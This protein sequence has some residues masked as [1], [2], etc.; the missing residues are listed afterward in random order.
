[1]NK[2]TP[3]IGLE[4]HVQLDTKSKLFCSCNNESFDAAP[5]TNICPICSGQP[6][7]L[8][9]IN[10]TAILYTVKAGI[11]MHCDINK[12]SKWDRKSYFYPDLPKG[13]QISQYDKP[14]CIGGYIDILLDNKEEKRIRLNRI[15]LEEDAGKSI[16]DRSIEYTYLDYNRCGTPLIEIVSEPDL[17]SAS[18]AD[19]YGKEIRRIVRYLGISRADM[20]K[21]HMRFDINVNVKIETDNNETKYTP[22]VEVK[23]LNSFKALIKAIE[24]EIN[25]QIED[26]EKTGITKSEKNKT[27]RLWNDNKGITSQMRTKEEAADYR[28]FPDPDLVPIILDD[29]YINNVK[30]DISELPIDKLKKYL[31]LG[32]ENNISNYIVDN[33]NLAD[34]LDSCL[35][36]IGDNKE[37][38]K[39]F[40]NWFGR[41]FF[42]LLNQVSSN[43]KIEDSS[44]IKITEDDF[45]ELITLIVNKKITRNLAKEFLIDMWDNDK[46]LIELKQ[47]IPQESLDIDQIINNVLENNQNMIDQYKNGNMKVFNVL[48]GLV[49]KESKGLINPKDITNK[50]KEILEK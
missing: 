15:H 11:A 33:K 7:T 32:L 4:T 23:N 14:L 44:V 37:M 47:Q 5:N 12:Y 19:K 38:Q 50:L 31:S 3:I 43:D 20:E 6:G 45:I 2:Y 27:T 26:F 34:Y 30:K 35:L 46:K 8:P 18:E 13:Y 24:F 17:C 42:Q 16:H 41:D 40:L 25:R 9:V 21:G 48:I 29:D 36:K 28:Y 1:M 22:I 39:E 49:M 10:K